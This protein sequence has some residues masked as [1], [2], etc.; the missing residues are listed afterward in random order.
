MLFY[1]NSH[2]VFTGI[3][4]FTRL[5]E[6]KSSAD[7]ATAKT[8]AS[9][10]VP[11]ELPHVTH[12]PEERTPLAKFRQISGLDIRDSAQQ[13]CDNKERSEGLKRPSEKLKCDI[14]DVTDAQRRVKSHSESDGDT[15][16]ES[17]LKMGAPKIVSYDVGA[18]ETRMTKLRS[19][20]HSEQKLADYKTSDERFRAECHDLYSSASDEGIL[21][22]ELS[23]EEYL[24]DRTDA[25]VAKGLESEG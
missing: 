24:A 3:S 21:S 14:T 17:A 25:D 7:L 23:S 4:S 1:G 5:R 11:K 6:L 8:G 13:I 20:R 9:L 10:T 19:R 16:S 2:T 12:S 22:K 15:R 18:D